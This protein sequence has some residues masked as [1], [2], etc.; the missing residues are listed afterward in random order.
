MKGQPRHCKLK[1][2]K[3]PRRDIS[4]LGHDSNY[5][6]PFCVGLRMMKA[7]I[8]RNGMDL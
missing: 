4:L 8:L 5:T 7:A 3:S 6:G 1:F 2:Y